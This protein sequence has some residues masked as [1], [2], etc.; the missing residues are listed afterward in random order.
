MTIGSESKTPRHIWYTAKKKIIQAPPKA[1]LIIFVGLQ[2][3]SAKTKNR[4]SKYKYKYIPSSIEIDFFIAKLPKWPD[5]D[6][7]WLDSKKKLNSYFYV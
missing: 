1:R 4:W 7:K 6:Q 2:I 5:D 3:F